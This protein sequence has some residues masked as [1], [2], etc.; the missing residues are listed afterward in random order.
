MRDQRHL[1]PAFSK[2]GVPRQLLI[3]ARHAETIRRLPWPYSSVPLIERRRS[4]TRQA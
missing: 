4:A 3:R 2:G 1:S